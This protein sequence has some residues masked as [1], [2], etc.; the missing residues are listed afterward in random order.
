MLVD[1]ASSST[2]SANR[3]AEDCAMATGALKVAASAV[4]QTS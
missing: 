1:T 3:T 2:S 4:V